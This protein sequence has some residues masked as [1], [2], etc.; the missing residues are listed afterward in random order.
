VE[1]FKRY[2]PGFKSGIL[3][4]MKDS[5]SCGIAVLGSVVFLWL[6][7]PGANAGE[8]FKCR[9]K[10]GEILYSDVACE[11]SGAARLGIVEPPPKQV[12]RGG[13]PAD[14][15]GGAMKGD[16]KG[17]NAA[18]RGAA[19]KSPK[20]PEARRVREQELMGI[21][22][23]SASTIEQKAAAQEEITSNAGSGVCKLS[24]EERSTRDT[25]FADLGGARPGRVAAR[26]VLRQI[27]SACERI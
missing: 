13:H 26:R 15:P 3:S 2:T 27:L 11:K 20:D 4:S 25:A 9:T 19:T 16:Q 14:A 5:S 23:N 6:I 12:D 10:D 7:V 1:H 22:E 18:D 17:S 24:D 8:L 21:L